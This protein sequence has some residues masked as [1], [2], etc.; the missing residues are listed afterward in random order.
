[1]PSNSVSDPPFINISNSSDDSDVKGDANDV[2]FILT[3]SFLI[4]TMQS[5]NI[6]FF[7]L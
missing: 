6:T 3:S 5:G 2:V 1:M 4:F 7:T